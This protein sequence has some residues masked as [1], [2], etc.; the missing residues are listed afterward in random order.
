MDDQQFQQDTK[1]KIEGP[2]AAT[3]IAKRLANR[4]SVLSQPMVS[5]LS[6]FQCLRNTSPLI[7]LELHHGVAL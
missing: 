6:V 7:V 1:K 3:M 4:T 2:V 5:S